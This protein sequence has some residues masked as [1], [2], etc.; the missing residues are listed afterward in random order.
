MSDLRRAEYQRDI[1]DGR[2]E[3]GPPQPPSRS[4]I[5]RV[6]DFFDGAARAGRNSGL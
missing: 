1:L 2:I 4:L 3:E 5:G 6:I